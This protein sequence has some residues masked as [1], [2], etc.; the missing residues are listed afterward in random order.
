MARGRRRESGLPPFVQKRTVSGRAYFYF[1]R[2]DAGLET[3]RKLPGEPYDENGM[4][5]DAWWTT[6]RDLA[7]VSWDGDLREV[8]G[9]TFRALIA[10]YKTSR[11]WTIEH[12][13]STRDLWG[14]YLEIICKAWGERKVRQLETHHILE[15]RDAYQDKPA[16]ANN[17]M[18]CLSALL[19]YG[20]P[21]KYLKRNP[22]FSI[23]GLMF[24]RGDPY[25]PWED[26]VLALFRDK[27]CPRIWEA[28]QLALCTG[29]RK[30]DCLTMPRRSISGAF[31]H[32]RQSKTGKVLTIALH[33]GLRATLNRAP[34]GCKTL[35]VG[36]NGKPWTSEGFKTAFRRQLDQPAFAEVKAEGFR[37]HGLRTSAVIRLLE[38]GC[39]IAEVMSVTGQSMEMVEH[40]AQRLDRKRLSVQAVA[41]LRAAELAQRAARGEDLFAE[42]DKGDPWA[43]M[44]RRFVR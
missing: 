2:Q 18:R 43:Q 11:K 32:V 30:R 8:G 33:P 27:G 9:G 38:S 44:A 22:C 7:G 10:D 17:L 15:L 6:Y 16:K 41:R 13:Q 37:F 34:K 3:R 5:V 29:Q 40:Y 26:W 19:S 20:V 28:V 12:S 31:V 24:A 25:R 42:E 23:F 39:S 1:R 35:L 4:P 21:R 36:R 14:P